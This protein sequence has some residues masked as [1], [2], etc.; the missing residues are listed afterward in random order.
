MNS[1]DRAVA[2]AASAR[3]SRKGSPASECCHV[4]PPSSD[5]KTPADVAIRQ[6]RRP[7]AAVGIIATP[8]TLPHTPLHEDQ[9][10]PPSTVRY[11]ASL[12]PANISSTSSSSTSSAVHGA[13][14]HGGLAHSTDQVT[15][16]SA[17]VL[18]QPFA[19]A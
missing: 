5:L 11:A 1:R 17:L 4:L 13:L 14:P 6:V 8:T 19:E 10:R 12:L 7:G 15:P 2:P 16:W 18:S 3:T 9:V